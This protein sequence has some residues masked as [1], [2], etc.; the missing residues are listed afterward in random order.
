MF[1]V[2][3]KQTFN[4]LADFFPL[5]IEFLPASRPTTLL[6]VAGTATKTLGGMQV[7]MVKTS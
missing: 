6:K 1:W 4:F 7:I 2:I 3:L 5:S